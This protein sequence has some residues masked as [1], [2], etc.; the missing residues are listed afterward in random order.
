M[1]S[2]Q[3]G[4]RGG[5][6]PTTYPAH[7]PATYDIN[8]AKQLKEEVL[9]EVGVAS[10]TEYTEVRDVSMVADFAVYAEGTGNWNVE[11]SPNQGVGPWVNV[12]TLDM[13]GSGYISVTDPHSWMRVRLE[14]AANVQ[15]WLY[16]KYSTF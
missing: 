10:G 1:A 14:N 6:S 3:P 5:L 4:P 7:F 9:R 2:G 8:V 15:V 11:V 13:T 16:K 12:Q